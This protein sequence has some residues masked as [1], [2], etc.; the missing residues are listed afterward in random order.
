MINVSLLSHFASFTFSFICAMR[1]KEK[2][3]S[4][5]DKDFHN[6]PYFT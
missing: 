4:E 5:V 1:F 3:E 2:A 6:F